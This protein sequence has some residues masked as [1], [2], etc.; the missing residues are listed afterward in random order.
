MP[1]HSLVA[2]GWRTCAQEKFSTKTGTFRYNLAAYKWGWNNT[3]QLVF[4]QQL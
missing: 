3:E 1:F 4:C 2:M